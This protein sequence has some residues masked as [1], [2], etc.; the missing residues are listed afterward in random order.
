MLFVTTTK[1][2]SARATYVAF[3]APV[4]LACSTAE[5]S[6][7]VATSIQGSDVVFLTLSRPSTAKMEALFRGSIV[8]DAAGCLR[9]GDS[10]GQTVVW[11][12]GYQMTRRG[13][14]LVVIEPPGREIGTIGGQ[15]QLGGGEVS[16]LHGGIELSANDRQRALSACPG[17]YW[18]VGDV[19]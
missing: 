19:P 4:L 9:L 10:D 17:R 18:I 8:A 1:T 12:Y 7:P 16:E 2:A 3:L 13:D 5:N 15:F 11:P 14:D 6:S